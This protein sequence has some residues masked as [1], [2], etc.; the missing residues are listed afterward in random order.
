MGVGSDAKLIAGAGIEATDDLGGL[1]AAVGIDPLG[2]AGAPHL[3]QLHDV[4]GDAPVGVFGDLP[5]E[6]DSG[7]RHGLCRE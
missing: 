1:G 6:S 5:G 2:L 7:V 4:L 3:L